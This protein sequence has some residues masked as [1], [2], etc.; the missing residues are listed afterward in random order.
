MNRLIAACGVVAALL[1]GA[2]P[3][4]AGEPDPGHADLFQHDPGDLRLTLDWHFASAAYPAWFRGAIESELDTSWQDP[5]ANN[6]DVPRFDNGGDNAGGGTI[7]YTAQGTSPCTGATLWIGCNPIGGVRG[8]SIYVRSLPSISAP[9]WLWYQRDNTCTDLYDGSPQPNDG[10]PT[11]VC[12]SVQRV[13]AHESTHVTLLRTH[14][15]DGLDGETIM[16]SNTP[17]PNGSPANWNRRS[18]LPCDAA[19]AQLEYGLADDAGKLADCFKVK[20]GDGVKGLNAALTL[21]TPT[22]LTR[23]ANVATT[24]SGRLALAGSAAYEDLRDTPLAGRLVRIDRKSLSAT[25]WTIG[26][27]TASAIGTA[28]SNWSRSITTSTAGTYQ[29]RAVFVTTAAETGV[30]SSNQVAWTI[31][32]ATIGCPT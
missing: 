11:S 4:L 23:C 14:Y 8:F 29:Y 30:N 19:A 31:N 6:S 5:V 17:T 25:T 24:V 1:L 15:D 18:F 10:F 3:V 13:A 28:G 9:T 21:A 32:W 2:N 22:S 26:V 7:V 20:P 27:L 16:Q 12:F